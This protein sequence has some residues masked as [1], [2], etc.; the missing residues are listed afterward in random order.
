MARGESLDGGA[1]GN[2]VVRNV[3]IPS[4]CSYDLRGGKAKERRPREHESMFA[5][6]GDEM[7]CLSNLEAYRS[8]RNH[9][10]R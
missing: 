6:C 5:V 8:R 10:Q 1:D 4:Q 3:T 2:L 7:W 9:W